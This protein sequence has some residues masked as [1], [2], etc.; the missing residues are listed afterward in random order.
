M[1]TI[2][3]PSP[4]ELDRAIQSLDRRGAERYIKVVRAS[5]A[6]MAHIQQFTTGEDVKFATISIALGVRLGMEV[7][8]MRDEVHQ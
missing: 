1:N 2:N 6:M 5:E 4:Q 7:Q 3:I 8:R